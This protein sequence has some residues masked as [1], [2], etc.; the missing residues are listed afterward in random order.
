MKA[1]IVKSTAGLSRAQIENLNTVVD[2]G[3]AQTDLEE[4]MKQALRRLTI[5][6]SGTK[7]YMMDQEEYVVYEGYEE[8]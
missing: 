3:S 2:L 7:V 1:T 8:A 6:P 5:K 4:K